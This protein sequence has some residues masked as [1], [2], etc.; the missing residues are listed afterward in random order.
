MQTLKITLFLVVCFCMSSC[1]N[2]AETP[3]TINLNLPE[4]F[5][6]EIFILEDQVNGQDWKSGSISVSVRGVAL[7]KDLEG[8][9]KVVPDE[10]RAAYPS[11]RRLKNS[12]LKTGEE[13]SLWS[14]T[15][16]EDLT[17]YFVVGTF[18]E[19]T[20]RENEKMRVN[21]KELIAMVRRGAE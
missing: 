4:S 14:V 20:Q 2:C 21:W 7:V 18:H 13:I 9:A 12:V 10:F 17:L 8:L 19:K 16:V 6:G 1:A 15:Y 5:R 3:T 11:G